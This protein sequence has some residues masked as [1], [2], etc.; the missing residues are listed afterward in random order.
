MAKRYGI[1]IT[2]VDGNTFVLQ[3][4]GKQRYQA[5]R[6]YDRADDYNY[7]FDAS[8]PEGMRSEVVELA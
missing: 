1:Q 8:L 4:E 3:A 2:D 6:S 7:D 5:F